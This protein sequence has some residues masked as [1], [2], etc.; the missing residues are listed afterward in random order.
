MCVQ[1]TVHVMPFVHLQNGASGNALAVG[2]HARIVLPATG[3]CVYVCLCQHTRTLCVCVCVCVC[4][5]HKHIM[6]IYPIVRCNDTL[7]NECS[8][9]DQ[10]MF[11]F[12]HFAGSCVSSPSLTVPIAF[13]V[14]L[15]SLVMC[16]GHE[17]IAQNLW[18]DIKSAAQGAYDWVKSKLG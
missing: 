16:P 11:C 4:V 3:G 12:M 6:C 13:S 9:N 18:N 14:Q 10:R 2:R 1:Q 17:T 15:N 8:E 5:S 7:S